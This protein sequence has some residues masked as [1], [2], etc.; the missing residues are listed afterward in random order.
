M[1]EAVEA[2]DALAGGGRL[3]VLEEGG[4]AA[5]DFFR[6]ERLG[7][8]AEAVERDAG[9]FRALVPRV[10]GNFVEGE[11]F[12][13]GE[14]DVPFLGVEIDGGGGHHDGGFVGLVAGLEDFAAGV[15]DAEGEDA[16]GG[17]EQVFGGS[18]E[19]EQGG[20]VFVER[21]ADGHFE[22]GP[23]AVA[24]AGNLAVRGA[25]DDVAGKRILLGHEVERRVELFLRH[26]PSD[27]RAVGELGG[28]QRLADAADDAGLDHRADP[29]QHGFQRQP[30]FL[31]DATGRDG[32]GIRR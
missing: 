17:H 7:D 10:F 31:G 32:A 27:E 14:Q 30:G 22:R 23:E 1:E 2:G 6:V 11:F 12:L 3:D 21:L 29:L 25:D 9:D 8:F 15:A 19:A 13:E 26:L 20:G 18:G 16:V 4:E 28:K 5:D 24:G